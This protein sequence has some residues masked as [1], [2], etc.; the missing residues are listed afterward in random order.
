MLC[1]FGVG[2]GSWLTLLLDAG[3]FYS[4]S[5][6]E[7]QPMCTTI[8]KEGM[9][10]EWGDNTCGGRPRHSHDPGLPQEPARKRAQGTTVA[11]PLTTRCPLL[12]AWCE[13]LKC[14]Y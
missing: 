5:V 11:R 9:P 3:V 10:G 2:A 4:H 14:H 7:A 13:L 6:R 12:N 1:S 8:E